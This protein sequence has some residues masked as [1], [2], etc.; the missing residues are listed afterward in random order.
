MVIFSR[1]RRFGAPLLAAGLGAAAL[2]AELPR[3]AQAGSLFEAGP[4]DASQ[5][6]L[7]A[8]PIGRSGQRSQLNI[9]EQFPGR[10]A[11]YAVGTGRPAPVQPLLLTFDFTGHCSRYIDANGFSVRVGESDLATSY[12]LTVVRRGGDNLLLAAPTRTGAGPEMVVARSGGHSDGYLRLE[13]EP[14]WSLMRRRFRGRNLG[15]VYVY[16]PAFP[17]AAPAA[18]STPASSAPPTS[19]PGIA[20]PAAAPLLPPAPPATQATPATPGRR[21]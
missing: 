16:T 6:V 15:H 5:F 9:Y 4:L 8:A 2:L 20:K 7:V 18:S 14:G 10:R 21:R 1:L 11:C 19:Q 13:F 3:A 17:A 12:R